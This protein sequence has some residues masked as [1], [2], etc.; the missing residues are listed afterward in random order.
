VNNKT[1]NTLLSGIENSKTNKML[2]LNFNSVISI[3]TNKVTTNSNSAANQ[4]VIIQTAV[5]NL[6]P[7]IL[8]CSPGM[9]ISD[10]FIRERRCMRER[11]GEA[12]SQGRPMND[13]SRMS[14]ATTRRSR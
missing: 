3:K 9:R 8:G 12:T 14:T 2:L 10:S 7:V 4:V 11:T 6:T 13:V 5:S 1:C